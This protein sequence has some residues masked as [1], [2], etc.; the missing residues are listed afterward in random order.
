MKIKNLFLALLSVSLLSGCGTNDAGGGDNPDTPVNP[1]GRLKTFTGVTFKSQSFEYDGKPHSLVVEGAPEGTTIVYENNELTEIGS[2]LAKATLSKEGYKTKTYSATL[3]VVAP[4]Q[5]F[6]NLVFESQTVEYDGKSHSL[7][8]V[9]APEGAK[10]TYTNNNKKGVG[11]YEVTAKVTMEGYNDKV[12]TATLTIKARNFEGITFEDKTFVY[13]AKSHSLA[14]AGLPVGA[15]VTYKNNDKTAIG[16]YEV[17]ATI[18]LTGYNTLVLKA[19]LSIVEP[20]N[21]I[22][23]DSTKEAFELNVNTTYDDLLENLLDGN[24]S[25]EI[26]SGI[27]HL[28]HEA[29]DHHE[30]YETEYVKFGNSFYGVDENAAYYK[31][32]PVKDDQYDV[33]KEQ[34]T[35]VVGDYAFT[36]YA[37]DYELDDDV[38]K[39]PSTYFKETFGL[40]YVQNVFTHINRSV[41]NKFEDRI[42]LDYYTYHGRVTFED[43][44]VTFEVYNHVE[45]SD[46]DDTFDN[47]ETTF[48]RFYNIGNTKVN[49]PEAYVGKLSEADSYTPGDLLKDGISYS[50]SS[51][52]YRANLSISY[53]SLLYLEK[54]HIYLLPEIYGVPVK[55]ISMDFYTLFSG[56]HREDYTDIILDVEFNESFKYGLKYKQFGSLSKIATNYSPKQ[57]MACFTSCG[58]N[59]NYHSIDYEDVG[60]FQDRT[61]SELTGVD[62]Y[63]LSI[64]NAN[65]YTAKQIEAIQATG[66]KV[67]SYINVGA[68]S[69]SDLN[70]SKYESLTYKDC[71]DNSNYR[72]VDVSNKTW[73]NY[74]N[75]IIENNLDKGVDGFYLDG[76]ET[77]DQMKVE[78][79]DTYNGKN[80]LGGFVFKAY[81]DE[82]DKHIVMVHGSSS[83]MNEA[84]WAGSNRYAPYYVDY[85]VQDQMFTKITDK[86]TNTFVAQDTDV[87]NA[88]KEELK[89]L[90]DGFEDLQFLLLEYSKDEQIKNSI[91]EYSET[92]NYHYFVSD[93]VV[94]N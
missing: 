72:W 76:F 94:L 68:I 80:E 13:N 84:T 28:Y 57:I 78:E 26:E 30:Y 56:H 82:D 83:W 43:N 34:F 2:V 85:Y 6:E 65:N 70:Y 14:V 89:A 37:S 74:I 22:G 32:V 50:Y 16:I 45:H 7:V 86:D 60:F 33:D 81:H 71:E 11:T 27:R 87:T 47:E 53:G 36:K 29:G 40:Y 21:P 90:K 38:D 61:T 25:L 15:T 92:A 66:T 55:Q 35:R 44:S 79:L 75:S 91:K 1:D 42:Y 64:V 39:I 5:D 58:A 54:G 49:I 77:Y 10:I 52:G 24:Y 63:N 8:V 48:Y 12:L 51:E 31:S 19:T 59:V 46:W 4:K 67:I 88:L 69:K 17:E 93:K 23:T 20:F 3:E 73:V 9:G 62:K 41:D 18:T